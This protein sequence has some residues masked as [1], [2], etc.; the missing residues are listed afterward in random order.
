MLEY[1]IGGR[2]RGACQRC[3]CCEGWRPDAKVPPPDEDAVP[4]LAGVASESGSPSDAPDIDPGSGGGRVAWAELHCSACRCAESTHED[5]TAKFA[6][7][8]PRGVPLAALSWSQLEL[9][10]WRDTDGLFEPWSQPSR[11]QRGAP[12]VDA[13]VSVICPTTASRRCFHG[14]LYMCW[15]I[16]T[17][18]RK[19]L[20][21]VD[22]CEDEPSEFF[23]RKMEEDPRIVYRHYRVPERRWSIGLKRNL[24]CYFASGEVI[25]HFDDDDMYGSD[26]L[27]TMV[28]YL[29]NPK[30]A[31]NTAFMHEDR[32][33]GKMYASMGLSPGMGELDDALATVRTQA[34]LGKFGAA[35]AKLSCWHTYTLRT[36]SFQVL[37]ACEDDERE[38]YGWGFSFVYLRSAWLACPFAHMGLGEDYDFVRRLR[39]LGQ[40]VVLVHDTTGICAHTC[41]L[42]NTS[43]GDAES[44]R[45]YGSSA[46]LYSS[47]ARLVS[48]F[49]AAAKPILD[50]QETYRSERGALRQVG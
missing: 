48:M 17:Y 18:Q 25:A 28:E 6:A 22:T 21:I 32:L 38:L 31:F 19:Q 9:D 10:L 43:G 15:R 1:G 40:P 33:L 44:P 35:C 4:P 2:L 8:M 29:R 24:A 41:H 49:E 47:V 13:E 45:R 7:Y 12:P 26:Y 5:V 16:Q 37:N 20:V 11:D 3:A 34:G 46:Q 27:K 39:Q 30:S 50:R 14:F 42:D 23:V 36:R